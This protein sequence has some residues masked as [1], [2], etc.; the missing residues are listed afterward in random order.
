MTQASLATTPSGAGVV[1]GLAPSTALRHFRYE[2]PQSVSDAVAMLE[3]DGAV[4]LAGGT[5][6]VIMRA[7]GTLTPRVL[8]D[9][10]AIPDLR[11]IRKHETGWTL[12][13]A[14]TMARFAQLRGKGLDA[15]VDGAAVLGGVQTRSRATIGGNVCRS[16]PAG[17]V[18]PGLLVLGGRATL[19]S[20]SG[21]RTVGLDKFFTGPGMNVRRPDELVTQLDLK[22]SDGGSAFERFTYR[23]WM[24]LA[25]V[26]LAVRLELGA[27]G[28]CVEA[29]IAAGAVG[30]VPILIGDAAAVLVGS[31]C[32][33]EAI[34]AACE[35]IASAE[36]LIVRSIAR[37]SANQEAGTSRGTGCR[38][39][40]VRTA[41][42]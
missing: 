10:K 11:M 32:E 15:L 24:D 35:S 3:G 13:A 41:C 36:Q 25:V 20:V 5:D 9:V 7:A 21:S 26:S 4:P 40:L 31:R 1:P 6:V 2:R 39:D 28:T 22:P 19:Q 23:S 42:C 16:S 29:A 12:G 18:L 37:F 33:S 30:P 38:R 27:D 17:D 8:V 14:V 34:D